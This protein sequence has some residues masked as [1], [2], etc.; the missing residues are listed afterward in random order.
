MKKEE[1]KQMLPSQLATNDIHL[2]PFLRT[3]LAKVYASYGKHHTMTTVQ[4]SQD[5]EMIAQRLNYELKNDVDFQSLRTNELSYMFGEVIKGTIAA[6]KV[7]TV[8]MK[9]V[10]SW[11]REYM[12]SIERKTALTE[13]CHTYALAMEEKPKLPPPVVD[14]DYMWRWINRS[15][16][17]FLDQISRPQPGNLFSKNAIPMAARDYGFC[18]SNFL[19]KRGLI[20]EDGTLY[21]FFLECHEFGMEEIDFRD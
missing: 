18:Q 5:V 7:Q 13:Y 2:L 4:I 14:D 16:K 21:K 11:I 19:K 10:F 20:P 1:I 3:E 6:D 15:Y 9:S 17:L 8:T 12:N